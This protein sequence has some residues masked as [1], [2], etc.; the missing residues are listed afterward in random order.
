MVRD[1]VRVAFQSGFDGGVVWIIGDD[2][3]DYRSLGR[4]VFLK[5]QDGRLVRRER[6]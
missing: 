5:L 3:N 6:S 2:G 4:H 1:D